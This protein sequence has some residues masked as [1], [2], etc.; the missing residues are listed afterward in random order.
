[1]AETIPPAET[2]PSKAPET[3]PS[4]QQNVEHRLTKLETS[5][6]TETRLAR[7]ESQMG[8]VRWIGAAILG[9]V[10]FSITY[11]AVQ[12]LFLKLV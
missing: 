6:Q 8:L 12:K 3:A 11:F 9:G 5:V 4:H 10:I 7:L 1:M 2:T